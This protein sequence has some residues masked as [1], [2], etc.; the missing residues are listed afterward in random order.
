MKS[1]LNPCNATVTA[2]FWREL[3]GL[4][5]NKVKSSRKKNNRKEKNVKN[6]IIFTKLLTL[7]KI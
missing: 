1:T 2:I 4:I 3:S 6:I 5:L 7:Q